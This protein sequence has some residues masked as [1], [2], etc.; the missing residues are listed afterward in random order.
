MGESGSHLITIKQVTFT[1]LEV[2][3]P[4]FD[5]LRRGYPDFNT[6]FASKSDEHCYVA[7]SDGK[8]TG[9]MYLKIEDVLEASTEI[10]PPFF[11]TVLRCS[12]SVHVLWKLWIRKLT[13]I[14]M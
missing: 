2:S 7:F 13:W 14:V 5:S 4:F 12:R 3:D 11:L 1:S 9:L 8:L 10:Y 6:W